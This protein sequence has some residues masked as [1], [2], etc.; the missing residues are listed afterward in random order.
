MAEKVRNGGNNE[1]TV[2]SLL[3]FKINIPLLP[4]FESGT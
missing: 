3:I 2:I 4:K 1:P